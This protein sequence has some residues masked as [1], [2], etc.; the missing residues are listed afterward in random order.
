MKLNLNSKQKI[1]IGGVVGS[2]GSVLMV[3]AL[4]FGS[5][6]FSNLLWVA[7]MFFTGVA[8]GCGVTLA[9]SGLYGTR[10]KA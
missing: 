2:L 4:M 9:V 8:V 3:F 5:S 1:A 10:G 7:A 6:L